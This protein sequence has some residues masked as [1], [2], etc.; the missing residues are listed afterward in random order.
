M[1]LSPDLPTV[2]IPSA[3]APRRPPGRPRTRDDRS[4]DPRMATAA[5]E[6]NPFLIE[7]EEYLPYVPDTKDWHYKWMR[8]NLGDKADGRNIIRQM[9]SKFQYEIVKPSDVPEFMPNAVSRKDL[10][11]ECIQFNDVVLVRCPMKRYLQYM[12][13]VDIRTNQN[14]RAT[15][16]AV[17]EKLG[18]KFSEQDFDVTD[19]EK[20]VME[21]ITKAEYEPADEF[22]P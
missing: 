14:Q 7:D 3:Q 10:G 4:G 17:R 15:A 1:A 20:R 11:G 5:K 9:R 6:A 22:A 12:E 19:S 2:V 16:Q 8:G 13:A 21:S 18:G